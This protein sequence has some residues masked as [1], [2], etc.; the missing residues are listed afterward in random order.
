[1]R[2]ETLRPRITREPEIIR[3]ER[4]APCVDEVRLSVQRTVETVV[5]P[6][7]KRVR[8]QQIVPN[9]DKIIVR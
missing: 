2:L 6:F 8:Q 7:I 9:A 4:P 5:I 3:E 1:M